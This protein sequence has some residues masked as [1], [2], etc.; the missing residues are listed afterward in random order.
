MDITVMKTLNRL[1]VIVSAVLALGC[2]TS[3]V[4][5][6]I[7][8]VTEI[9]LARCFTPM[10]LDAK[11]NSTL[12]DVVAFKWDVTS[13]AQLY[14]LVIGED[15]NFSG[16]IIE[17]DINPSEVPYTIKLTADRTYWFKVMATN[18]NKDD[19]KWAVYEKSIKTFAVKDP[20]FL[21][22]ASR[23]ADAIGLAWSK[24]V[25]DYTD[26][27]HIIY[28]PVGCEEDELQRYD[29]SAAEIEAAEAGINGL[30]PSTDYV[31]TLY[32]LSAS[33]GEVNVWTAPDMTGLTEVGTVAALRQALIDGAKIKLLMSGSPY[34]IKDV[35]TSG[36]ISV[37]K[38]VEIYGEGGADGSKPVIIGEIHFADTWEDG[39]HAYFEDVQF[40]GQKGTYGFPIQKLNG[41]TAANIVLESLVYRNCIITGY[42]KGLIYEWSKTMEIGELTWDACEISNINSDGTAGGDVIDLRGASK[43]D[44]L[45]I[46]GSTITQGMRT[47]IRID[48]ATIGDVRIENNTL[49]NL[50]F[51]DNTNNAGLIGIQ[52]DVNS[53]SLKN[54]LFIGMPA[55]SALG[56]ANTKYKTASDLKIAAAN[57]WYYDVNADFFTTSFPA[58]AVSATALAT[59]PCYN[60]KGGIFNIVSDSEIAGKEVGAPKWW[61][62]YVE[63]PEDLTLNVLEGAHTWDFGNAKFFTGTVK[64]QM[65]RDGLLLSASEICPISFGDDAT[66]NFGAATVCNKKGL[67]TDGYLAFKVDKPGSVVVKPVSGQTSHVIVAAASAENPSAIT[68]KGGAST[69][70]DM[71]GAQK[72]VV[73]DIAAESIVYIYVSG[74]MGIGAL[75]WSADVSPVNTALPAPEPQAAP[76][77]FTA[78][79]ATDITVSWSPVENAASYSVV[80]SGKTYAVEEGTS[81][82]IEGKTTSMLDKGSYTVKVFANPGADDIYNTQSEAGVAAFAVLPAGGGEEGGEFIVKTVD[83]LTA[84]IDAG[85]TEI[86]LAPGDYAL[87]TYALA[88]SLSLKGQD[89]ANVTGAFVLS[90][91]AASFKLYGINFLENSTSPAGVFINLAEAGFTCGE[92]NVENCV[93]DGFTKSV[94]YCNYD[95]ANIDKVIFKNNIVKNQGTGQGVFD[96][97]KGVFG[98]I[99]ITGNTITGGRDFIRLDS[100]CSTGV[101]HIV[102]NTF[103]GVTLGN[104]NGLL[105]VRATL[106]DYLVASNLFLNEVKEGANTL[107]SK[108]SGVAIPVMKNNFFYNVDETNFFSGLITREIATGGHGVVLST[109]PVKDAANGDYT[110]VSGLA[111]SN[112]VGAPRWNPSTVICDE[113]SYTVKNADE[114]VV[115]LDAGK[116]EITL[117]A[118]GSPYNFESTTFEVPA[119]FH[120]IGEVKD[121][122]FPEFHGC[123]AITGAE[124]LGEVVFENV[125]FNAETAGGALGVV[126]TV[127]GASSARSIVMKNC[128]VKGFSKS[129]LYMNGDGSSFQSIAFRNVCAT[130]LGTGQGVYDIRKG[131]CTNIS[132]ENCTIVGG[133]DLVR[134]DAGTITGSFNFN[135]NTV[136]GSN[137]GINSNAIMYVRATPEVYNFK[138][139]L[140]LNEVAEG[141]SV[142]LSKASGVTVPTEAKSN[143]FYNFDEVNFFSGLFTKEVSD[144][145][146]LSYDPVRN[147]AEGDYM[148]VDALCLSSNIGAARW[149]PNAGR[150]TADFTV[151]SVEELITAIDAGKSSITLKPGTYDL[152]AVADASTVSGGVLTLAAPLTLK[153]E[154]KAGVAPEII[155][156]IKLSTGVTDFVAT[157]LRFNGNLK[158]IGIAFEIPAELSVGKIQIRDCEIYEFNKGIFYGNSDGSIGALIFDRLLVHDIGTGQ[159][160]IDIRKQLYGAVVI[161]NSTFYNGGRD[162]IRLDAGKANSLSIRNNTFAG[163]SIDAANSLLYVRAEM[164]DKYVVENN[165]FLNETGTSTILAKSGTVVPVMKNNWF[166]NCT[167]EAF[168][169]GTI[170]QEVATAGNGG[171]LTEDPC[172]DSAGFNF[173]VTNADIKAA[174]AGDPRW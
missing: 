101:V 42:S 10:N 34:N 94:V 161:E 35:E 124:D 134:A 63:E 4:D 87:G 105:Y 75:A 76:D 88:S 33:R 118:E 121:G 164:G 56:S 71:G 97:R 91:E 163:I 29:L 141:V 17:K 147:A 98:E 37:S 79:E 148:L 61:T 13:D 38:S 26:A 159:G 84:A 113:D 20:L 82:T 83:E 73:A 58:D 59:D 114:F 104:G 64:K 65:V 50:C 137:L 162:F 103:D 130:G 150:I 143:F 41:G 78:G 127:S 99:V 169:S 123:F 51:V 46:T 43:I 67:P 145:V 80:F 131:V 128:D 25:A 119:G 14:K 23:D 19:S 167:S 70:T 108:A 155:G 142:T 49:W 92:V 54:N 69:L 5:D 24:D 126:L 52:V 45:N 156:G 153:G 166:F 102:A 60:A 135:N 36:Q 173:T 81:Y 158:A 116:T 9:S 106:L 72:I 115:A 160:T 133:R 40:D 168:W 93:I 1:F 129:V 151:T 15:E 144:A 21:K 125:E 89:G 30:T 55:K 77:S 110:L 57:N 2:V 170:S 100:S 157:G 117:A 122:K 171:V 22:V 74:A 120:L 146:V 16:E 28:G 7:I 138:R 32:Y 96:F 31:F 172:T 11:V 149:N 154:K 86:T 6:E 18:E 3:C 62:P 140:F 165:L 132:I 44:A 66:L 139:N 136:D 68:V 109:D 47:F 85:K 112:R 8:D 95:T 27:T 90:G 152:T 39:S 111:I 107:L 48:A 174:G 12:G 53:F